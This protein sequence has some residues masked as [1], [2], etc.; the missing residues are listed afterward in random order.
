M[1]D[2]PPGTFDLSERIMEMNVERIRR[3]RRSSHMN[4]LPRPSLSRSRA[5]FGGAL[6]WLGCQLTTSGE[7][8]QERFGNRDAVCG[9]QAAEP[10]AA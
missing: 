3:D 8:L 1:S 4:R 2:F 7:D 9:P 10:P 5:W 6:A